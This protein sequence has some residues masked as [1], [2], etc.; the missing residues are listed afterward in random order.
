MRCRKTLEKA[1]VPTLW[2]RGR[3]GTAA[4]R[5]RLSG[6]ALRFKAIAARIKIA[7]ETGLSRVVADGFIAGARDA[8]A[9]RQKRHREDEQHREITKQPQ[10]LH[11]QASMITLWIEPGYP[12]QKPS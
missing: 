4:I 2:R 11:F 6:H 8:G 3:R 9:K 7:V 1:L 12:D 10:S 5:T